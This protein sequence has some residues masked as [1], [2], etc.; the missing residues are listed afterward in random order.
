MHATRAGFTL[1][2][3]LIVVAIIGLLAAIAIPA[4][5]SSLQRARQKKTM[6]ELRS[7]AT[8]VS[9]Y[10]TDYPFMPKVG[11]GTADILV[12]YLVPTYLRQLT[13]LDGWQR[14][15]Y[16]QANDLSYTVVSYGSDGVAQSNLTPGPTTSFSD[17]IVVS[18]GV[19]VQWP[20]GMQTN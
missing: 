11:P 5:T 1:V 7:L 2:E 18:N 10:A 4:L 3:L 12:P 9:A 15:I 6:A 17:D 19:F 16:Y 14:P 20:D 13:G 8:A